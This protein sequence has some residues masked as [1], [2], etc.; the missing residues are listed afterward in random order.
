MTQ[1]IEPAT[2]QLTYRVYRQIIK[3]GEGTYFCDLQVL[4][5]SAEGFAWSTLWHLASYLQKR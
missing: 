3:I 4:Q 2:F 5:T 1:G